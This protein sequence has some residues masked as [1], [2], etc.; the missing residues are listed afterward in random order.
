MCSRSPF[1]SHASYYQEFY[2]YRKT[3]NVS[4][5]FN[6]N[7]LFLVLFTL[8]TTNYVSLREVEINY[9]YIF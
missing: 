8:F 4:T 5:T 1:N 3:V 2:S 7:L 6:P 9:Q